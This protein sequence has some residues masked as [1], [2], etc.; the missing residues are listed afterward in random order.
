MRIVIFTDKEYVVKTFREILPCL[1]GVNA[2]FVLF[3][4]NGDI[5]NYDTREKIDL[6]SVH[7]DADILLV[8]HSRFVHGGQ[9]LELWRENGLDEERTRVVSISSSKRQPYLKR[10]IPPSNFRSELPTLCKECERAVP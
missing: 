1:P 4:R 8:D 3:R 5:C 6:A 7:K 9:I 10:W 2:T